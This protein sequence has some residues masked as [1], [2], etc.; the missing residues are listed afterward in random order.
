VRWLQGHKQTQFGWLL[1]HFLVDCGRLSTRLS[2]A[3]HIGH[4]HVQHLL[5]RLET[6]VYSAD[7]GAV[8]SN[9]CAVGSLLLLLLH[10]EGICSA[11]IIL[12]AAAMCSYLT[13]CCPA[14]YAPACSNRQPTCSN[15]RWSGEHLGS[16]MHTLAT[17]IEACAFGCCSR[18]EC[19]AVMLKLVGSTM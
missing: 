15:T 17:W 7:G 3:F 10:Y 5:R 12:S 9:A 11:T 2:Q 16:V 14:P 6:H 19:M 8:L 1:D 18:I 13:S 4:S